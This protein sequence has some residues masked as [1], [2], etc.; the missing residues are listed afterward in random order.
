MRPIPGLQISTRHILTMSFM[1]MRLNSAC[2]NN[3]LHS[4]A[5]Q[6][7]THLL[8]WAWWSCDSTRHTLSTMSLMVTQLNSAPTN[9]NE[10]D[11]HA[12]QLGTH[13]VQW[14]SWSC[15]STQ[16]ALTMSLKVT[17]L[18]FC[19]LAARLAAIT[20]EVVGF[21]EVP[22]DPL[23]SVRWLPL[24]VLLKPALERACIDRVHW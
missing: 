6:F 4:H 17:S 24:T 1:V 3:K 7:G 21:A 11:C 5:T 12:T 9:Y 14:P 2:T 15:D 20:S 18:S 10:L 8:H 13:L 19:C 23:Q 22:S 16:R